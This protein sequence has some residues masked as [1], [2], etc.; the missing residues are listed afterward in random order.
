[1]KQVRFIVPRISN[2]EVTFA[3]VEARVKDS[4]NS[5]E[6]FLTALKKSLNEWK[7]TDAGQEAWENSSEDFNVGDLRDEL[8]NVSI[9]CFLKTNGIR[10]LQITVESMEGSGNWQFD[11]VLMEE[12]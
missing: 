4:I 3:I 5:Q 7:K 9:A 11:D 8:P 6:D 1:M 2:D 10:S 12:D